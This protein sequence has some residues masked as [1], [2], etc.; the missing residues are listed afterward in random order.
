[1]E[2][3][4]PKSVPAKEARQRHRNNE[5][6]TNRPADTHNI[7]WVRREGGKKNLL[8]AAGTNVCK[9]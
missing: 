2:H 6:Q 7:V 9:L 5:R 1:M 4:E 8:A 3:V